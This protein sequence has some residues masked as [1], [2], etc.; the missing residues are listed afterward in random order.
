MKISHWPLVQPNVKHGRVLLWQ[1]SALTVFRVPVSDAYVK[2]GRVYGLYGRPVSGQ[3]RS[4][5]AAATV[6]W[7]IDAIDTICT[8]TVLLLPS[9]A[10]P[11]VAV[12]TNDVQP[13]CLVRSRSLVHC[14]SVCV[15]LTDCRTEE[16]QLDLQ[17]LA[18]LER[19]LF[20]AIQTPCCAQC[21][22]SVCIGG[23]SSSYSPLSPRVFLADKFSI[24]IPDILAF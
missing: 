3:N 10:V 9:C 23:L 13:S 12:R 1:C 19:I 18:S 5:A 21:Q 22:C 24:L 15:V 4:G 2:R 20:S 11:S 7:S 14:V 6:R 8:H 16:T 17:L